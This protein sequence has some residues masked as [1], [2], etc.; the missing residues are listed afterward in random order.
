MSWVD[1]V[2]GRCVHP[3]RV[4]VLSQHF[5]GII[6]RAARVLDVGCGDGRLASLIASKRPDLSFQG[7]DVLLRPNPA[8]TVAP[9]DGKKIPFGSGTF[10]V[11]M[12]SD[13]LHHTAD[14]LVL[15]REASRVARCA[16][17]IKDHLLSGALAGPTLAFMDRV[18]NR[19]FGVALPYNY[20]T[21]PQWM[22][23]FSELGLVVEVWEQMLKLYPFPASLVFDRSL[24]FVAKLTVSAG[25]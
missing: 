18:G 12:F 8:I 22:A 4:E 17:A 15:M 23:A 16:V 5:A 6:P 14:P 1:T 9:F 10:D 3:R 20:W 7:I 24:H 2:H 25:G 21:H 11:V 19:R 13:V